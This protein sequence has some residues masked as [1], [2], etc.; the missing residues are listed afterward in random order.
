M[1]LL[2]KRM[3]RAKTLGSGCLAVYDRSV[4]TLFVAVG[5][6]LD[7]ESDIVLKLL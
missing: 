5:Q 6:G 2:S 7:H 3:P 1:G 4:S